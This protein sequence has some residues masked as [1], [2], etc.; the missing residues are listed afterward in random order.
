VTT[1]GKAWRAVQERLVAAG[2]EPAPREGK[3]LLAFVLECGILQLV[4][5]ENEV[6]AEVLYGVLQDL[7]ARRETGEP[8]AYILGRAHFYGR[9]WDVG[10]GVLV[11]RPDTEV[12]VEAVLG[13]LRVEARVAE[14]GV[15]SGAVLGSVLAEFASVTGVG[16]E[17]DDRARAYAARNLEAHGLTGRVAWAELDEVG[18][19]GP[20]DV[21]FA[22]PPYVTDGEWE[23][24]E[25]GVKDFEPKLALVGGMPNGDGLLYY[26]AWVPLAAGWLK[27]GGMLAMEMG[28]RQGPAVA[29][30][31]EAAGLRNVRV[32]KDMAGRDRVVTGVR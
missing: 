18:D 11:P 5:R 21:V 16:C 4:E 12:L 6:L 25:G 32:L 19:L 1:V 29:A 27:P 15:G 9:A 22:N 2:L 7:T 17:V 23:A 24:L 28:W 20:Y 10:P 14:L 3:E 26:R 31:F 8:L 13:H 30:L